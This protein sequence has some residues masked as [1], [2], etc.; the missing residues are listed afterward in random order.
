MHKN[1]SLALALGLMAVSGYSVIAA[2]FWPWKAALFPLVIG[3]PVF[4]LSAAEAG[5]VVFGKTEKGDVQDFQIAGDLPQ[6]EIVRRSATAAAWIVGF[7]AAILLLGFPIAVPLFVFLY[8]KL[9]GK[10]SW[11]LS[12]V[13]TAVVWGFFHGL[14]D[15]MLHLPFPQG[16]LFEWFGFS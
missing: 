6:P 13:F 15:Q 11:T 1:A 8:L 16:W 14:F 5:W 7:F 3:I 12:I 4:I 10:E 2:W 9:Q